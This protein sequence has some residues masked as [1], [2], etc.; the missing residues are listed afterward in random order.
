MV[1]AQNLEITEESF[2]IAGIERGLGS[3][4]SKAGNLEVIA[5]G[6][7][8]LKDGGSINNQILQDGSGQG[9]DVIISASTLQIEGGANIGTGIQGKG[10]GGNLIVDAPEVQIVGRESGLF[11]SAEPNSSGDAGD[12]LIRTNTLLL[13]DGAQIVNSTFGE[14]KGGFL[15]INTNSLV[16]KN[17]SAVS[18]ATFGE[19]KGGSLT[20]N[21]KDVQ[22]IGESKD[23][24]L[25]G[26]FASAELDS[27]GD[28]GNLTINTNTLLLKDGAQIV[29]STFD[30]GKG[31]FLKVNA[32][33]VQLIAT[34]ED[35]QFGSGL[36]ASASS[37]GD[38]GS[39]TIN[40][41]NLLLKDGAQVSSSA[42]GSGKGGNFQ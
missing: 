19:G 6:T 11:A 5:T 29:N 42:F 3:D 2:L 24:Q 18:V 26:L 27:L 17:G 31:G 30:K 33:D 8:N 40:T 16:S 21:A 10:R 14:G 25:T 15:T 23:G 1:N 13:K 41:N 28:A 20:I 37:I 34:S 36:F 4:N 9:G 12:L 35:G 39:L 32:L 7:I 38:A 22:L